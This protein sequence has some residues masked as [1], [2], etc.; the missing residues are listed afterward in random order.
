MTEQEYGSEPFQYRFAA[1]EGIF[2]SFPPQAPDMIRHTTDGELDA[3]DE[4]VVDKFFHDSM[5]YIGL[6]PEEKTQYAEIAVR[7]L[8]QDEFFDPRPERKL[9]SEDR[10]TILKVME[11]TVAT[12]MRSR[13]P[14]NNVEV[15][16]AGY[17]S[18]NLLQ[19]LRTKLQSY[20][21]ELINL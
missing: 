9:Q 13:T 19:E 12:V 1:R 8:A 4:T 2:Q 17:L 11:R 21:D 18:P 14:L 15:Y 3:Q 16:F 10:I 6:T 20:R 5:N 7:I